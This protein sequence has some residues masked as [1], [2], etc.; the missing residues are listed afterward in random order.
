[1][2]TIFV[3]AI[4]I[5]LLKNYQK[6]FC[7]TKKYYFVLEIIKFLYL[8]FSIIF[9]F[10]GCCWFYTRSWLIISS[11][12]Y[13][14]HVPKLDFKN[15]DSL[16]SGEVKFLS[17]YLVNWQSFILRKFS[18]KNLAVLR[19]TL[20]HLICWQKILLKLM[21]ITGKVPE[22]LGMRMGTKAWPSI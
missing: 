11:K 13:D 12:V 4:K 7:S 18:R 22:S 10:L 3:F 9:S 17:W 8:T 21:L 16:I 1:M 20:I 2:S 19:A 5:K 6:C 14:I 15:T